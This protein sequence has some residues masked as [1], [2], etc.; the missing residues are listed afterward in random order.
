[1]Q[2]GVN[3]PLAEIGAD[4]VA[5]RDFVQAAEALGYARGQAIAYTLKSPGCVLIGVSNNADAGYSAKA[6]DHF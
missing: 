1:M 6:S 4:I 2:V 5:V 3:L